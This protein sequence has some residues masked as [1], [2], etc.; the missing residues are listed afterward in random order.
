MIMQSLYEVMA[1]S[2]LHPQTS[3]LGYQ[4]TKT[5]Q[6]SICKVRN[7]NHLHAIQVLELSLQEMQVLGC[8]NLGPP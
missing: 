2:K 1:V 7:Y 4:F 3:K 6:T 5:S 8:H